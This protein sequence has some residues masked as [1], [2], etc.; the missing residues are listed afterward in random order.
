MKEI[1]VEIEHNG[2]R[3]FSAYPL[4][5]KLPFGVMGD[6][7]TIEEAKE[8]FLAALEEMSTYHKERTGEDVRVK[9][10]FVVNFLAMLVHYKNI[11][12]LDGLSRIT[13]IRKAQLAQYLSCTRKPSEKTEAHI[14]QSLRNFADQL[15]ADFPA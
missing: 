15:Q 1:I 2:Q 13:R 12:T 8:D 11:L 9:V 4:Y 7:Y 14:K 5:E 3:L 10:V 6:G